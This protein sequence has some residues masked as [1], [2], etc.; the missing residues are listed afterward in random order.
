MAKQTGKAKN[1]WRNIS[2]RDRVILWGR[3]AARCSFPGCRIV[4]IEPASSEDAEATFG[5]A[6]H[7]VAHSAGGPR[8]DANYPPEKLDKYENLLLLCGNH[9]TIVDRQPNTYTVDDLISWKAEHEAWILAKTDPRPSTVAWQVI[10]HENEPTI[11]LQ[12]AITAI[13]PDVAGPEPTSIDLKNERDWSRAAAQQEGIIQKLLQST[14]PAER[15]FAIFSL[16]PISL[17]IHLG[18]ILSDRCRLSLFQYHRDRS[19]WKWPDLGKSSQS[20]I[21]TVWSENRKDDQG[22]IVVRVSLSAFINDELVES[23]VANPIAE[24]H[25]SAEN[26]DVNWLKSLDQLEEINL[27]FRAVLS[28]IRSRFGD[29]CS[30]IHLFYAGPTAGAI[31]LGRAINP[32]MNPP[33]H[34]YEY[35]R[36]GKPP[37]RAT[38][39]LGGC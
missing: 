4:L 39:T 31:N 14:P 22:A 35:D 17:A 18:F 8:S 15:R 33:V 24:A 28:E 12:E 2:E 5:Q 34:L 9:H 3:A 11:D 10:T 20:H 6:A 1:S 26:P 7:I 23:V 13:E 36:A 27:K 21:K 25:L 32:R 38:L 29:R 30:D 16:A 37:Y 19:S